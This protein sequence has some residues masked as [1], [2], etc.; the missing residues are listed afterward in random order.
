MIIVEWVF[1]GFIIILV[2][3]C[4]WK[5]IDSVNESSRFLRRLDNYFFCKF[6]L[7]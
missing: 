1:L 4:K 2:D 7:F 3:G 5:I 6:V